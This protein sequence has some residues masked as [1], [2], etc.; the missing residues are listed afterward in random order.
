[1]KRLHSHMV[2]MKKLTIIDGRELHI[3]TMNY[4]LILIT[5]KKYNVSQVIGIIQ[6]MVNIQAKYIGGVN[7]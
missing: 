3:K 6:T 2:P 4:G 5:Q 7:K 1:M